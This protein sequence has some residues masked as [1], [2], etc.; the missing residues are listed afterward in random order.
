MLL[1]CWRD[2]LRNLERWANGSKEA[3]KQARKQASK[4]AINWSIKQ[5]D[6]QPVKSV[7][8][9]Y[10]SHANHSSNQFLTIIEQISSYRNPTCKHP[11]WYACRMRK[12][13]AL[14][15]LNI[16]TLYT[17]RSACLTWHA[18]RDLPK[19]AP[20]VSHSRMF[21]IFLGAFHEH[22]PF[23]ILSAFFS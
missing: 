15:G 23:H 22:F 10:Y 11:R 1:L 16:S 13:S 4:Q 9:R 6:K 20:V 2:L 21:R 7:N 3:R 8:S 18:S 14:R 19:Q 5:W 17:I 12:R